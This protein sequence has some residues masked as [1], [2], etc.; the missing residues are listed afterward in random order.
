M[1]NRENLLTIVIP[2][3][4]SEAYLAYCLDSLLIGADDELEV[5]LVN[6]GSKDNTSKIGHEYAKKHPFIQ[7]V[8][9]ENGGHGSGVNVGIEKATGLYLKVLDSDDAL[10][11]DGLLYL[12]DHIKK[13][14]SEGNLPDLYLADFLSLSSTSDRR[15]LTSLKKRFKDIDEVVPYSR[16]KRIRPEQYFMM[17][18]TFVKTELLQKDNVRLLEH[19]FYEDNQFMINV[20]YRTKTLCYLDKPIYLYSVGREGQ[21]V[22]KSKMAKNYKQQLR[23]MNACIDAIPT[24]KLSQLE[25]RHRRIVV[26]ELESIGYLTYIDVHIEHDREKRKEYRQFLR[27]F[28]ARDPWLFHKIYHRTCM[29]IL[30]LIPPPLRRAVVGMGYKLFSRKLGWR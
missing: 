8:D 1:E 27:D 19:C 7:V 12:L 11:K 30:N 18:M 3:Y 24:E 28:K 23:V 6:D 29:I 15:I 20:L 2:A 21:S 22:S 14:A 26:H 25:K 17:H 5:I 13:H 9:K 10:D 16:I 4:N